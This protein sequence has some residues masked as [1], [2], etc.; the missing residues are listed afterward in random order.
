MSGNSKQR[1]INTSG[2]CAGSKYCAHQRDVNFLA[3]GLLNLDDCYRMYMLY[4]R[5][6]A[7]TTVVFETLY[8]YDVN[9]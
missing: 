5:P 2:K 7:L 1:L 3:L 4:P 6:L 9:S 8:K